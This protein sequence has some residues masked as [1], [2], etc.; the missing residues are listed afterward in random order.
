MCKIEV[1]HFEVAYVVTETHFHAWWAWTIDI[2]LERL[3]LYNNK[4]I[5]RAFLDDC[6]PI[7]VCD[8]SLEPSC[9]K[10]DQVTGENR[11]A[12]AARP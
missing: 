8:S 3:N 5:V 2:E 12:R 7:W 9:Y 11:F 1:I 4:C 6:G 10:T